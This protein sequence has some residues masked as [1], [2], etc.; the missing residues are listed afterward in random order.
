[1]K[2]NFFNRTACIL[3][4]AVILSGACFALA[5]CT[6][7]YPEVTITYS[8]NGTDYAVSYKLSR[9]DAPKTVQHFIE[10]ADADF[11]NGLCIHDYESNFLY[12]GGYELKDSEL[13]EKDY[14]S[15]VKGAEA[16]GKKFT[17]SVWGKR[18]D[19][20]ADSP[21]L[22]GFT[23][24]DNMV[25]MYTVYG[26]FRDNGNNTQNAKEFTHSYGALVMYY[27]DKGE[28]QTRV[29]TERNDGGKNNNGDK[30]NRDS[31]YKKNSATSLFYTYLGSSDLT[32]DQNYCVFG[33]V[34]DAGDTKLRE[35]MKAVS[36]FIAT[37]D[38]D[39][40]FTEEMHLTAYEYMQNEPVESVKTAGFTADY[41]T[42]VDTP[43]TVKSVKVTKY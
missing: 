5:G 33:K 4:A 34:T 8:F 21:V 41:D 16:E 1:M 14:F 43:I 3:S 6:T 2:K 28:D 38:G 25:P 11:Y 22:Q 35:L 19:L 13:V 36:D 9:Y 10:L 24:D 30:Y 15:F 20:L 27:T 26:E 23:G 42:P 37:L 18:S 32:L 17:Q 40:S 7:K 12:T 29:T 31:L 39:D